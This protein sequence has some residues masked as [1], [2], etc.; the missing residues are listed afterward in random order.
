M[1][2]LAL[3]FTILSACGTLLYAGPEALSGKEMKQVVQPMAPDCPSWTGFYIGAFGGYKFSAVD[4]DLNLDGLWDSFPS[5]RDTIQSEG[6]GDFLDTSGAE[7]GGLIGY[8][9]QWHNWVFGLEAAGGYLWLRDSDDNGLFPTDF[10]DYSV[11]TSFKT[12]YLTTIGGRIGYAWCKWLPYVTGGVA[13]GDI[14]FFQRAQNHSEFF[15][16]EGSTSETQVGWMVGGGLEYALTS[17]WRLRGQ[18]QYIDLGSAGFDHSSTQPIY[19]GNSH[20]DVREH[21][22]SFAIIYGF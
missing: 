7:L 15:H 14:D 3:A 22:A 13:I 19:F 20:I 9:Y 21:N 18:Y 12:H 2:R 10:G 1:K 4:V 8:N 11:S 5:P 16:E 6:S 17:H